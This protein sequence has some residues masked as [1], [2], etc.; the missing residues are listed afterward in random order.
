MQLKNPQSTIYGIDIQN[1]R[2]PEFK[3]E[4]SVVSLPPLFFSAPTNVDRENARKEWE[5]LV[6]ENQP[7]EDGDQG[8]SKDVNKRR[9]TKEKSIHESESQELLCGGVMHSKLL[10]GRRIG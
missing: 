10:H 3:I 4:S 6:N 5:K 1:F 2:R 7:K 8:S 9:K